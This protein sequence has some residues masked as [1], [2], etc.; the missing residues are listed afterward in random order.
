ML[1]PGDI[2]ICRALSL[3]LFLVL[4]SETL[5]CWTSL[6]DDAKD[7]KYE[8]EGGDFSYNECAV[9]ALGEGTDAFFLG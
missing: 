5:K 7:E 8:K 6:N 3:S 1:D 4:C 2:F 9:Q